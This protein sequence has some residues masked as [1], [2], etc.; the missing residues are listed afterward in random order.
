MAAHRRLPRLRREQPGPRRVLPG[1]AAGHPPAGGHAE[2]LPVRGALTE[3][4]RREDAGGAPARRHRIP[5]TAPRRAGGP[6]LDGDTAYN[7]R[8]NLAYSTDQENVDDAI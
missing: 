8:S 4:L 5:G 1:A 2:G 6:H 7:A 3:Q